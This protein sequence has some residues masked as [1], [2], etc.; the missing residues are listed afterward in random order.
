MVLHFQ[1]IQ[2]N[3]QI[4]VR[5]ILLFSKDSRM[6]PIDFGFSTNKRFTR[7]FIVEFIAVVVVRSKRSRL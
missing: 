3:K 5:D 1:K 7:V 6:S 2:I 4:F